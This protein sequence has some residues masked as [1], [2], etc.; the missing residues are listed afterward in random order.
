MS[1]V[2]ILFNNFLLHLIKLFL[3]HF[4]SVAFKETNEQRQAGL[5]IISKLIFFQVTSL[6]MLS[7]LSFNKEDLFTRT[8]NWAAFYL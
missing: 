3:S 6:S 7:M 4:L 2:F 5:N 1:Q 8:L